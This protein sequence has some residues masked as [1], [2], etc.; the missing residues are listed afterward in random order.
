[1][2]LFARAAVRLTAGSESSKLARQDAQ[3]HGGEDLC[4][5][6]SKMS[7]PYATWDP[8]KA[9]NEQDGLPDI[10]MVRLVEA[11]RNKGYITYQSCYGHPGE[12]D[13]TLWI[14]EGRIPHLT[15]PFVRVQEVHHGPEGHYW[16]YWWEPHRAEAAV[17]TLAITFGVARF[18]PKADWS[19]LAALFHYEFEW[20]DNQ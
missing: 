16:E 2:S 9:T 6:T 20:E 12:G 3:L 7:N 14:K 10:G 4:V 19:K 15:G 11:L 8:S 18:V 17:R 5:G 1:M 13:G